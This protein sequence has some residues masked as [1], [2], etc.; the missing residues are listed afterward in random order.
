MRS[1]RSVLIQSVTG[2]AFYLLF[3]HAQWTPLSFFFSSRLPFQ[4]VL[5]INW[6][7][8]FFSDFCFQPALIG[9]SRSVDQP[10]PLFWN[11]SLAQIVFGNNT[12]SAALPRR[13]GT[14]AVERKRANC[15]RGSFISRRDR[16]NS[17]AFPLEICP[18]RVSVINSR[19]WISGHCV[20]HAPISQLPFCFCLLI[21][22]DDQ[23]EEFL[24]P[25]CD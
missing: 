17:L 4:T 19:N 14:S 25:E 22:S 7:L 1:Y 3:R 12:S 10:I 6:F 18:L 15:Q 9:E 11:H 21:H 8:R 24:T 23:K 20:N 16:N 5:F 2:E 13:R